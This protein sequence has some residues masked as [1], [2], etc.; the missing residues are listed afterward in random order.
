MERI[1]LHTRLAP[2]MEEAYEAVHS[3]IPDELDALLRKSG[4]HAWRIFR[5]GRDLFHYVEVDDYAAFLRATA[6][7]PV[8]VAWQ[9]R[10]GQFLEVAHDYHSAQSNQLK[11]VWALP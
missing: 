4:V 9:Q 1:M 7:H 5:K 3:S 2:G 10:M 11:A 8:N 6:D